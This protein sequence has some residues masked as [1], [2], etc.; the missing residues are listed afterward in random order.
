[1]RMSPPKRPMAKT[2]TVL[3]GGAGHQ[4]GEVL[5]C[6]RSSSCST[7]H[8]TEALSSAPASLPCSKCQ[9][10][11]LQSK[12]ALAAWGCTPQ[13][14]RVKPKSKIKTTEHTRLQAVTMR[15][16]QEPFSGTLPYDHALVRASRCKIGAV[17]APRHA[18]H[19]V[20]VPFQR[21][22]LLASASVENKHARTACCCKISAVGTVSNIIH[23]AF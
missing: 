14:A 22:Q 19:L 21:V 9:S 2:L 4:V 18:M 11:W 23:G 16:F 8:A 12:P 7:N 1:M 17:S 13:P 15:E 10:R 6:R 3:V 5:P 20:L